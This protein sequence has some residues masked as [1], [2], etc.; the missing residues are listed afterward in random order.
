MSLVK[1]MNGWV[2]RALRVVA[3]IALIGTGVAVGG[4]G[5]VALAVVGMVPLAAGAFGVCLLAPLMR[6]SLRAH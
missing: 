2:G 5:G 4:G 3:G 6:V 1:W